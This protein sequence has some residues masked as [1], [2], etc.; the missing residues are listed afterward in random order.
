MQHER[1]LL[2][3]LAPGDCVAV[4]DFEERGRDLGQP[5]WLNGSDLAHVLP[6]SEDK[7][8]VDDPLGR[9]IEQRRGG[10]EEDRRSE[11]WEKHSVS[12]VCRSERKSRR[13]PRQGS[14]SPLEG[15][16]WQRDGSNQK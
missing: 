5:F 10:M 11:G 9:S 8:V 4:G 13:T 16:S 2:V 6:R 7:L 14:C 12:G 3:L 15:P 1:T